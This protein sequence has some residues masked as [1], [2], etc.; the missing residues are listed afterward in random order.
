MSSTA[1][2][3]Y[4]GV[5]LFDAKGNALVDQVKQVGTTSNSSVSI[6]FTAPQ[7]AASGYVYV[8]KNASTARAL[9]SSIQ[10]SAATT[11]SAGSTGSTTPA[12]P[13]NLI[14][15]G[16]FSNGLTGWSNW[17]NSVA[18]GNAVRVGT[19]AGGLAQDIASR[20]KA[21]TNYKVTATA[22]ITLAAEGVWVGVKMMDAS[23]NVVVNQAQLVN[24]TTAANV[25]LTFTMPSNAVSGY[26]YVWKNTNV[27]TGVVTN[28]SV[29][30]A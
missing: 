3:V 9:V 24:S 15:N 13:V 6:T 11:S 20:L 7:G 28:V 19:A 23:G 17:G 21:G 8:W 1:E 25:S 29:V 12:A 2:G 27:A 4:I 5:K 14:T 16:T 26:V 22:N 30:A 10:L 18:S